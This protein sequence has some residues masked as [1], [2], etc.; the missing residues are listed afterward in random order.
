MSHR[1]PAPTADRRRA[2]SPC[3]FAIV[4]ISDGLS[5]HFGAPCTP[6]P[7]TAAQAVSGGL[8]LARRIMVGHYEKPPANFRAVTRFTL[9]YLRADW[10]RAIGFVT[11]MFIHV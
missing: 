9:D 6:A 2:E 7:R 11:G 1:S 4:P 5:R 3:L 10:Q 8:S